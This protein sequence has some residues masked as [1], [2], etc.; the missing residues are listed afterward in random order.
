MNARQTC[1]WAL[2]ST[3]EEHYHDQEWGVPLYDDARLFEFLLLEGL[4]AGLS[5]R[6]ILQ[7]RDAYRRALDGFD[8]EKI[9]RYDE[10][11]Q[12]EL[13]RNPALIRNRLKTQAIVQNARAYLDLREKVDSFNDYLWHFT[14][15]EVIQ[16]HW[17][18]PEQVPSETAVSRQLSHDL[19]QH[20]FKFT[21]P[22]ICYA[23]MQA[24]GRV[25][26]HLLSCFRHFAVST[27]IRS[28]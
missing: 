21:G 18:V 10:K 3:L 19:K 7:K 26:D 17:R 2:Q 8:A 1:P 13:L 11:K 15:G 16:N 22:V 20:G 27:Q 9:A 23:F 14:D 4:Q 12:A 6:T 24:T 5:W 28:Y 25:N